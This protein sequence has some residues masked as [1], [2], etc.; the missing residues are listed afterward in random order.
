MRVSQFYNLGKTQ[1]SLP[2]LDVDIVK[3]AKLFLNARAISLLHSDFGD[4]CKDLLQD[5]F[6]EL[7]NAVKSE[8]H[9]RAFSIL[10]QLGEPNETH[11][12]LSADRSEGRGLGPARAKDIWKSFCASRAVKTGLLSDLED[13]VLLID[14]VSVD[15]LSDMITNIIRGPLIG[16][17]QEICQEFSITM[18]KEVSSGPVWNM[19][20][21]AWDVDYVS[22]PMPKDK[23]LILVPKSIVR[24]QC[25]YSVSEYYRHYVL[26]RLK[27]EET[28]RN[29]SLVRIIKTGKNKGTRKVYKT[30]LMAKYGKEEKA[31]S[32]EQT[33]NFPDI[34]EKYKR[35]HAGPTPALSH[36]QIAE[37]LGVEAPDWDALLNN[38]VSLPPG[39]KHA[40]DYEDAITNLMTALFYPALVDPETQTPIHNGLKRVDITF[41]NYARTGFFEWLARS[42][43]CP[44]VFVECKNFGEELG[45]PEVDQIAMRLSDHRGMFGMVVCR[46]IED[47]ALLLRRCQAIAKD[48]RKFIVALDDHDIRVLIEEARISSPQDYEFSLLRK[49]FKDL[50][51]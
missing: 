43:R 30:D 34:F 20:T 18:A 21:K 4:H 44:Y 29:S 28:A 13:T 22:L 9:Q 6:R 7:L 16:Y 33:Q 15:I 23:K 8:D 25:D 24:S 5:F 40:Y 51:F 1:P 10:S 39:K 41:T 14:G 38:V 31:V 27:E 32:I 26:E 49:Y 17:T 19:I 35:E 3:G 12:G 46:R 2:F 37:A 48:E 50:V 47:R 36:R 11:L 42:Y 45:N